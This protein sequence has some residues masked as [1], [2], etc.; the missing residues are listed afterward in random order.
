MY[1]IL[2]SVTLSFLVTILAITTI[3]Q[4]TR[5]KKLFDEPD[6]LKIHTTGIPTLGGLGVFA[7]FILSLLLMTSHG[8]R[9]LQYFVAATIT[10]FFLGIKDDILTITPENKLIPNPPSKQDQ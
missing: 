6:E 9:E 7:G 4:V 8:N 5:E 3:I 2:F 1:T 10:I